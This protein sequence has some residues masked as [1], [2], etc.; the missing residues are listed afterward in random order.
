MAKW[1]AI[2]LTCASRNSSIAYQKGIE[3]KKQGAINDSIITNS[4][5]VSLFK[6]LELKQ[7]KGLI[8]SESL[9]ICIEDPEKPIGSGGATLNALL[10]VA[11]AFSTREKSRV[12]ENGDFHTFKLYK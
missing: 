8:D 7:K 10:I 2:V 9:I 1:D 3:Y 11:E 12:N 5:I 4:N 6:E